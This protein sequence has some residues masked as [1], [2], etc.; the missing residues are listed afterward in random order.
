MRTLRRKA[1]TGLLLLCSLPALAHPGIGIVVDKAGNV[2]FTD[3]KQVWKLAPDGTKTVAVPNVHTHELYLDAEGNLL[4][5]HLWYESAQQKF[6][7]YPW[8]LTA[9]GKLERLAPP[10][11][12][13]DYKYSL[14]RDAAGNQYLMREKRL[15]RLRPDGREEL[16][17]GGAAT[18][19][20]GTGAVAGF[21]DVIWIY[22]ARDGNLYLTDA[23]RLRR[24]LPAGEV[25]TLPAKFAGR[26]RATL[27]VQPRH[28]LMGMA[29]DDA[30]N[31]FVANYGAGQVEKF[32]TDGKMTVFHRSTYPFGPT[33]ITFSGDVAYVLEYAI[34]SVKVFKIAGGATTRIY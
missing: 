22:A 19:K 12:G 17:A 3:L 10:E 2:Y 11:A 18:N 23:G 34:D 24:V 27:W 31:V 6:W 25:R 14:V 20:D 16:V 30:G 21:T 32:G 5:E 13:F 15:F 4:G 8:K 26:K 9:H 1:A 29:V 28:A 33:G 7:H